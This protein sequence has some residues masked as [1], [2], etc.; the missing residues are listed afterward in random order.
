MLVAKG[1][2]DVK[3][4]GQGPE[5]RRGGGVSPVCEETV[6]CKAGGGPTHHLSTQ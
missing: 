5:S 4:G 3:V 1:E 6:K 2:M